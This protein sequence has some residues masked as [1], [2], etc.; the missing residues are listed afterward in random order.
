MNVHWTEAA[1][2]DLAAVEAYLVRHSPLYARSLINRIFGR[3]AQLADMP[4][5]GAVVPEY[6]DDGLREVFESPY[7]IIYR[8][9]ESRQQVDVIAVVHASRRLPRGL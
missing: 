4:E 2:A 9:L 1:L 8:V 6:E 5:L 3:T 7:R